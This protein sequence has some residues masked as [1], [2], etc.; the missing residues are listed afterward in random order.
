MCRDTITTAGSRQCI[1]S[2][3]A[4]AALPD[5]CNAPQRKRLSLRQRG[6]L[7]AILSVDLAYKT[8][9]DVGV[10]VFDQ[11]ALRE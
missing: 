6:T 2:K 9:S 11:H 1:I 10:V 4:T 3:E 7:V 5:F 8:Y